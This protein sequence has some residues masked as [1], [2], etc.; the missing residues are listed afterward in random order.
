MKTG[1]FSLGALALCQLVAAQPHAPLKHQ[2]LH[3]ARDYVARDVVVVT[4]P[5]VKIQEVV[6]FVDA[7]GKPVST[8]TKYVDLVTTTTT[9]TKATTTKTT[10]T[11]SSPPAPPPAQAPPPAAAKVEQVQKA[12]APQPKKQPT[13]TTAPPASTPT[14]APLSGYEFA[15]GLSYAPYEQ[16]ATGGCKSSEQISKDLADIAPYT[17]IRIYGTDCGQVANVLQAIQG[18]NIK[19]FAG[20]YDISNVQGEADIIIAAVK[21]NGG[22]WDAFHTISIGNEVVNNGGSVS[23]VTSAVSSGR[24]YLQN[25]GYNGPVVTVDTMVA[26]DANPALW[27]ASDYVAMNCH[28]FFDGGVAASGAGDFVAGWV[29]KLAAKAGGK[30]VAVTE[31]GWPT[32]GHSHGS[33]PA[34]PG[35]EEQA[36]ATQSLKTALPNNLIMYSAFNNPWL[37]D[38][39]G[40]FGAEHFWGMMNGGV[41]PSG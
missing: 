12:P 13:S 11:T 15:Y 24:S 17:L 1:I 32:A 28:A 10:T 25:A 18:K 7:N 20:I 14:G 37:A 31:S 19:V 6:V 3:H 16:T 26:M 36:A 40:T 39:P 2:H 34:V 27:E 35:A 41:A 9:T 33:A 30:M 29:K 8:S 4:K 22:S 5:A 23:A 38:N 21:A